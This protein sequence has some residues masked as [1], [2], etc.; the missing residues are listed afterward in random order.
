MKT[1]F[2]VEIYEQLT[3]QNDTLSKSRCRIFY[4]GLNRNGT[5]IS[6]EF[7]EKL[8]ATIP[9]TPVKGIF[10]TYEGEY[11]DHGDKRSLGRIYGVVPENCNFKW[12]KHL[13]KDGV[14]R[15]YACVDVLIYTGLYQEA[16]SIV[17]SPQSM[18]LWEPSIKGKWGFV[19]GKRCYI[20]EDASFLGLQ[21]LGQEV[22]PCFEGASFFSLLQTLDNYQN[23]TQEEEEMLKPVFKLSDATKGRLIWDALNSNYNEQ[24]GWIMEYELLNVYDNYAVAYDIA[25]NTYQRVYYT[26]DDSNDTVQITNMEQCFIMD[27]T[28]SEKQTL[29]T[30]QVLN[31]GNYEKIDETY[32]NL[33]K[34]KETAEA[35]VSQ[36]QSDKSAVEA[37]Y[38]Q[39][40]K[41][42]EQL[43]SQISG[44]QTEISEKDAKI[45][46]QDTTISTLNQ[47]IVEKDQTVESLNSQ[48]ETLNSYK[49][50]QER[51][52]KQDVLNKFS[53]KL[54]A[55]IIEKYTAD[56]DAYSVTD[57]KKNLAYEFVENTPSVFSKREEEG[58]Y[59]VIPKP[60]PLQGIE[61]ILARYENKD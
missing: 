59:G 14:E 39:L 53:A 32:S 58:L 1:T 13:D 28:P 49:L 12:E 57:L 19:D 24:G 15:E 11:T 6:D 22:E 7:A 42:N 38:S 54:D 60:E 4:K 8:I 27:V 51:K 10:D 61:A 34:D 35:L 23:T 20:F 9:Y 46:E 5:F 31:G 29:E 17:G 44:Y 3:P 45:Q 48:L 40:Q 30:L 2:D 16:T 18:E 33:V 50:S 47:S 41:D 25:N 55:A 52:E 36:L 43:S 56:I 21:V 37:Q 26:K